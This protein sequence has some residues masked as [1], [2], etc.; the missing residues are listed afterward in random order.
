M[1]KEEQQIFFT[2][3]LLDDIKWDKKNI[4]NNINID[5]EL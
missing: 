5:D 3:I 2:E 4:N 1:M